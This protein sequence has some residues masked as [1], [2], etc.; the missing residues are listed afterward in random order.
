MPHSEEISARLFRPEQWFGGLI[1]VLVCSANVDQP[2]TNAAAVINFDTNNVGPFGHISRAGPDIT[3]GVTGFYAFSMQP[4]L[5]QNAA[6][7]I[8]T[9]WALKNG[10][11]VPGSAYRYSSTGNND[12]L[13]QPWS[14]TASLVRGDVI[15]FMAQ[16]TAVNGSTLDFTAAAGAIPS[17]PACIIDIRGFGPRA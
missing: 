16:T 15:R 12:T 10:V 11:A 3:I 1:A 2:L 17:S 13:V 7:N 9:F 8:T 14:V 6:A 5:L 4:Q